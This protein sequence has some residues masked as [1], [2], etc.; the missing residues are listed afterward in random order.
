[1]PVNWQTR[2]NSQHTETP[3][4]HHTHCAPLARSLFKFGLGPPVRQSLSPR[5]LPAERSPCASLALFAW[6]LAPLAP[7]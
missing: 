5:S 4:S 2:A 6:A 3:I 1:M 7:S